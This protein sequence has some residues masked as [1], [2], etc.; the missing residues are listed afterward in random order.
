MKIGIPVAHYH[1]GNPAEFLIKALNK[2][3]GV[4]A[5]LLSEPA[6]HKAFLAREYDHFL[7]VDSGTALNLC[8]EPFID[9]DM[10]SISYW[11]IDYR[12]NK[13]NPGRVPNDL[14]TA[15]YLHEHGGILF[16]AQHEDAY[17]CAAHGL[18]RCHWI[19][20][21][22]DPD[23]WDH[24][25]GAQ[26]THD[27]G[28]VGNV[29]DQARASVLTALAK[30]PSVNTLIATPKS[31]SSAGL[32]KEEAAEALSTCRAGFN[33]SSFYGTKYA[34]DI[35]M[36]FFETL[37]CGLPIIT[38]TVPSLTE[39]FKTLPV[40]VRTYSSP[41]EILSVTQKAISDDAFLHSGTAAREYI[42]NHA[43]YDHR[44]DQILSLIS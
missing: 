41:E 29:W 6:F 23:V 24:H 39:L 12:H 14:K 17:E 42:L 8:E 9:A 33:I 3:K 26:K 31:G 4:S 2:R 35:N 18:Q 37:S 43:T 1:D 16:Q 5:T 32:W 21:A 7:C 10:S 13:E 44:A 20:L 11:F 38:N 40:F 34:F 15:S 19:P 22:A 27:I 36:R 28:F 25:P 30:T